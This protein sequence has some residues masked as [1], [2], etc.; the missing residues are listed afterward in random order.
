MGLAVDYKIIPLSE[1][2]AQYKLL[3]EDGWALRFQS[4]YDPIGTEQ[5]QA[6]RL[7][8][9]WAKEIKSTAPRIN[10]GA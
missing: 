8:T 1:R 10:S 7:I 4:G 5:T 3:M 6:T 9:V 2:D